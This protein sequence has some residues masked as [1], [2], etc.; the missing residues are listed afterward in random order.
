MPQPRPAPRPPAP[1]F[2]PEWILVSLP[3]ASRYSCV[4]PAHS[5]HPSPAPWGQHLPSWASFSTARQGLWRPCPPLSAPA[6]GQPRVTRGRA[7]HPWMFIPWPR[8]HVVLT[9]PVVTGAPGCCA[10]AAHA[11]WPF[12]PTLHLVASGLAHPSHPSCMQEF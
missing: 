7:P 12:T 2:T 4:G 3:R 10:Q 8:L 9:L 1:T 5:L 6:G 11:E